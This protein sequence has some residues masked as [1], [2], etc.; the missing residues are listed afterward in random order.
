MSARLLLTVLV[1]A[2]VRLGDR[3]GL[4]APRSTASCSCS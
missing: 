2:N 3:R 4:C 1:V